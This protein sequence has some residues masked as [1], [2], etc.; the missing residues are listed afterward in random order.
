MYVSATIF[1]NDVPPKLVVEGSSVE[2]GDPLELTFKLPKALTADDPRPKFKISTVKKG[3]GCTATA[4]RLDFNEISGLP[5]L[6][7]PSNQKEWANTWATNEDNRYESD[8]VVC[9]KIYDP[10]NVSLY[11][12]EIFVSAIIRNDDPLPT[13]SVSSPRIKEPTSEE[14]SKTLT[15]DVTLD[16]PPNSYPISLW[17]EDSGQGTA[18]SGIDYEAIQKSQLIFFPNF[19]DFPD[20]IPTP[21]PV[22]DTKKTV[23][24]KLKSDT[25]IEGNE[26]VVLRFNKI[27]FGRFDRGA[28]NLL[29]TGT[30]EDT[31]RSVDASD[32]DARYRLKLRQ[33]DS[34]IEGE[35]ARFYVDL[36]VDNA[37][38]SAYD[39]DITFYWSTVDAG[40]K[41]GSD[42]TAV[43]GKITTLKAGKKSAV[44]EVETLI[45]DEDD[46]REYLR[47]KLDRVSPSLIGK[48]GVSNFE[49]DML[50]YDSPTLFIHN[51]VKRTEGRKL[52]F[53]V[54]IGV[55]MTTD[56]EVAWE[57]VT[58]E[59]QTAVA[60]ADYTNASGT[61][62]IPKG[63]TRGYIRIQTLQDSVDES[64]EEFS[65]K[66]IKPFPAGVD[67]NEG[68]FR[69][70]IG[71]IRDDDAPP[72]ITM[73]DVSATE[74]Q[75]MH[76][77]VKLDRA[78]GKPVEI[79]WATQPSG[80]AGAIFGRDYRG[81][82][83]G[84]LTIRPGDT[85]ATIKFT[86][87][88]DDRDEHDEK[89]K[90]LLFDSS[91][92]ANLPTARAIAGS[93]ALQQGT[94]D[95]LQNSVPILDAV[96]T[97]V[98][99]D[100]TTISIIDAPDVSEVKNKVNEA[101]FSVILSNDQKTPV[102]VVVASTNG[103]NPS[104]ANELTTNATATVG[105]RKGDYEAV[106]AKTLTFQPG[107]KRKEVK[108]TI[109]DDLERE[110]T[111]TFRM[112]LSKPVGATIKR[113]TAF[114]KIVDNDGI[115]YSIVNQVR[116]V[117]EGDSI[118]VRV[119]RD[120]IDAST[121]P[122]RFCL[123]AT[124]SGS[125]HASPSIL[126]QNEIDVYLR[127]RTT[128][129]S[130]CKHVVSDAVYPTYR[131]FARGQREVSFE[132]F[133]VKDNRTEGKET[134]W[135]RGWNI[136]HLTGTDPHLFRKKFTIV[137]AEMGSLRIEKVNDFPYEGQAAKFK[138]RVD[139][140]AKLKN[141][142]VLKFSTTDNTATAG[143][144]YVG[145][146]GTSFDIKK[147][148][149]P[150][151][152]NEVIAEFTVNTINDY[153]Y[154]NDENFFVTLVDLP[155]HLFLASHEANSIVTIRDE[156]DNK[157]NLDDSVVEEGDRA[158][159][160]VHLESPVEVPVEVTWKTV[161]GSAKAPRDFIAVTGGK[162]T[163]PAGATTATIY[164]DTVE[165]TTKEGDES[166]RIVITEVDYGEALIG[167]FGVVVIRDDDA[168]FSISGISDASVEENTAWKS[169][170]PSLD[171]VP[172]GEALW[173]VEGG[174]AASFEIDSGTGQL[175]LPVQNFEQP[176]DK[177]KDNIY[178]VTVRA[179]DEDGTTGSQNVAVTVTDVVYGYVNFQ[180]SE[181]DEVRPLSIA[182]GSSINLRLE[183]AGKGG[184]NIP[185][186]GAP[187][188]VN[189]SWRMEF[190]SGAGHAAVPDATLL[191]SGGPQTIN[192][193][194][195]VS[196]VGLVRVEKDAIYEGYETFKLRFSADNDDVLFYDSKTKSVTDS[197][198]ARIAD[199]NTSGVI[200]S[201]T[202]LTIAEVDDLS[203]PTVTE[204]K[205]I[206]TVKL[207]T[208]PANDVTVSISAGV[209]AAVTLDQNSLNFT[210]NDWNKAQS[211]TVTAVDDAVE[212]IG[213]QREATVTHT[214]DAGYGEAKADLAVTVTDEEGT[215]RLTVDG[216]TATP[217]SQTAV[218]EG[219]G[220]KT[221]RVT[222]TLGGATRFTTDKT[223]V[224]TV[225]KSTDTATEG[226]D[227]NTVDK[228]T[229]TI[230]A[231]DA[232]GH[233]DFT[234]TPKDDNFDETTETLS[235]EGELADVTVTHTVLTLTDD[236]NLPKLVLTVD[237]DTATP[238]SQTAVDE[239]GGGKTVRVTAAL[240]G[241]SR[242][243][244]AKTIA[245]SVGNSSDSATEGTD[246]NTVGKQTITIAAGDASGHV[247]FV[248]T[249][250]DDNV[251]ENDETLSIEGK[252]TGITVTSA[253]VGIR[254]NDVRGIKVTPTTL[255]IS[256]SDDPNT[257]SIEENVGIF[258]VVLTS[259][260]TSSITTVFMSYYSNEIDLS[261]TTLVCVWIPW[262]SNAA[263]GTNRR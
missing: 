94:A 213:R 168:A 90:I 254:D 165:D 139:D 195:S 43:S 73:A 232:S 244:T 207:E 81:K 154:E 170:V 132:V 48:V 70:A 124:G 118:K 41:G 221:V 38:I 13:V 112:H 179:T 14:D 256:K 169:N 225:G 261:G 214:A 46:P 202:T 201:P 117:R 243:K 250:K 220:A 101:I 9:L 155:D 83:S 248:L 140:T 167:R 166:F 204:H 235:I 251:D 209:N 224:V 24:V 141:T 76:F 138:V 178:K 37:R 21:T 62:T 226:T 116:T 17:Y 115:R 20:G 230:V 8:E 215:L 150:N 242:F 50:I 113:A 60:G 193:N 68:R 183:Y 91:D 34:V 7:L 45:D 149:K 219:G 172:A 231:G 196:S 206:Y 31:D 228:Q 211:V 92:V 237:V 61:L 145:H 180:S 247:E 229:I 185:T 25:V 252:L 194:K 136:L 53:P 93:D 10:V 133:A 96:G 223:V 57:T 164:V 160:D 122:L 106:T 175:T 236:D 87:V 108:V 98:D 47:V 104:V 174:D 103:D 84:I 212:N 126:N 72:N 40:A 55:A 173:T 208:Q 227:Y 130:E 233:V 198:E 176:A 199:L 52:V 65:V 245:V 190:T 26:S 59:G 187:S 77:K 203:T 74:G 39:K 162:V 246:Y 110:N 156:D 184:G 100:E 5:V 127:S 78:S 123:E 86:T 89:F 148:L 188:E 56:I 153:D 191:N 119:Q 240:D 120:K 88:D 205:A 12:D 22:N 18:Q 30:I 99:N 263:P 137:D 27:Q 197:L 249:P 107:E 143:E 64:D 4:N 51:A 135:V 29:A 66:L 11:D 79:G 192:I 163:I 255:S 238:G 257:T 44:L 259:E 177:N 189:V 36:W 85:S 217:G 134:F 152:K 16:K 58:D 147:N 216:D 109:N 253:T 241:A 33:S 171:G 63:E 157:I 75:K 19:Y 121:T 142:K 80:A 54:S 239:D 32:G 111:E 42:F 67:Q 49:P 200:L 186:T 182:E 262:I 210:E 102:T 131:S 95:R 161:A 114:G 218:D 6:F 258:S 144:D 97:I 146:A 69:T 260:P 35:T 128:Q 151:A 28:R 3:G 1:N 125:G 222:A 82:Q 159:L 129:G 15:F 234:F 158:A 71:V 105:L 23:T 2:E 181:A